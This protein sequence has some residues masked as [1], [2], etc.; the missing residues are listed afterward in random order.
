MRGGRGRWKGRRG[1]Q[2]INVDK[3][4][5]V[6]MECVEATLVLP[7]SEKWYIAFKYLI[8]IAERDYGFS[9]ERING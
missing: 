1:G 9:G 8:A 5:L 3:E 2:E 7:G 6:A 4:K